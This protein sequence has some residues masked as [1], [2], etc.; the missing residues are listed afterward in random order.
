MT[1]RLLTAREVADLVGVHVETVLRWWRSGRLPGRRLPTGVL[2][3]WESETLDWIDGATVLT[4]SETE[5][6]NAGRPGL[7]PG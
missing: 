4:P 7:D 5:A 3:F 6:H 1:D 2:R